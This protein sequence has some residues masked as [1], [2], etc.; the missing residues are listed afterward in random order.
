MI[1]LWKDR[2]I[3]AKM[4]RHSAAL[5]LHYEKR[6]QVLMFERAPSIRCYDNQRPDVFGL[7]MASKKRE[8]KSLEV[9][10]KTSIKDFRAE[11]KKP[12]WNI[13]NLTYFPHNFWF[14]CPYA[15]YGKVKDDVP[16]HAGFLCPH[17]DSHKGHDVPVLQVVKPCLH[18][19]EAADVTDEHFNQCVRLLS[20]T[21]I[22]L[23][24][25]V[26]KLTGGSGI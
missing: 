19:K 1:Y 5:F 15:I 13:G 2:L 8:R 6:A 26:S 24:N 16:N 10:I 23:L 12:R 18:N 25:E 7:T 22:S 20:S 17:V 11:F 21:N 14:A 9:E 4:L 3:D